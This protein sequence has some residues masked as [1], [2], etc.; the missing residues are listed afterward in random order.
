MAVSVLNQII[1]ERRKTIRGWNQAQ[2]VGV[3]YINKCVYVWVG[4]CISGM[5]NGWGWL[6]V[7]GVSVRFVSF[8]LLRPWNPSILCSHLPIVIVSPWSSVEYLACVGMYISVIRLCFRWNRHGFGII[9]MAFI[10]FFA[11]PESLCFLSCD[12]SIGQQ[13]RILGVLTVK[14]VLLMA[15]MDKVEEWN[16]KNA[17]VLKII[18]L[19][20]SNDFLK[21]FS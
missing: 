7:D 20:N 13:M 3:C 10:P 19:F 12:T 17:I 4:V 1:G 15:L 9:G 11:L 8:G 21:K 2:V 6:D 5:G 18:H 16:K 14:L